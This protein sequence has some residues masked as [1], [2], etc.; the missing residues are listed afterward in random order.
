MVVGGVVRLSRG[1]GGHEAGDR[2]HGR[3]VVILYAGSV[4]PS[5]PATA[6]GDGVVRGEFDAPTG[7]GDKRGLSAEAGRSRGGRQRDGV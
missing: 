3:V 6:H 1:C 5:G 2:E 4:G 7:N